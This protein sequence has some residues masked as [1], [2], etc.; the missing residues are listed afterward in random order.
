MN[1][2]LKSPIDWN[3]PA[4]LDDHTRYARRGDRDLDYPRTFLLPAGL[5]KVDTLEFLDADERRFLSQV[6]EALVRFSDE[7]L[8]HQELFRRLEEFTGQQATTHAAEVAIMR[9][10]T[11]R[12]RAALRLLCEGRS[13]A[14]IAWELGIAEKTARNHISNL[15]RKLGVRSRSEA[16]VLAR[17]TRHAGRIAVGTFVPSVRDSGP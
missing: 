5:S 8:K 2:A 16:M 6:L 4:E 1:A 15:Y 10:L 12:E 13:N 14:Q 9:T 17:R 11:E 3:N 7:E